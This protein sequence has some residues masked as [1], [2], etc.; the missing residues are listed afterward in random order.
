[1]K[2]IKNEAVAIKENSGGHP[3]IEPFVSIKLKQNISQILSRLD[4]FL[5]RLSK[6][7]DDNSNLVF[8]SEESGLIDES[9]FGR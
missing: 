2:E 7:D 5:N 8:L 3:F 6:Y 1:M 4:L 9:L